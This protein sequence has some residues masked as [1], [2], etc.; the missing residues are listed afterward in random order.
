MSSRIKMNDFLNRIV[1]A[2]LKTRYGYCNNLP[3][4]KGDHAKFILLEMIFPMLNTPDTMNDNR[5][6]MCIQ[7]FGTGEQRRSLKNGR[8]SELWRQ[9]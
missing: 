6:E 1:L 9:S 3:K 8:M 7:D 4:L 2:N 5:S